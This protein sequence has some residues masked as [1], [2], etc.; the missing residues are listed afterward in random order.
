MSF[1][2]QTARESEWMNQHMT[3]NDAK[4]SD[5]IVVVGLL[6]YNNPSERAE[7]VEEDVLFWNM[8]P[9]SRTE[10]QY[11]DSQFHLWIIF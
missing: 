10:Y 9:L 7:E 8:F 5:E 6:L 11:P 1:G 3:W 4:H 2:D